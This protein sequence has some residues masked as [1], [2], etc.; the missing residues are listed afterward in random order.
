M[1]EIL[2]NNK[3]YLDIADTI[4]QMKDVNTTYKPRQMASALKDIYSNEVEGILPLSFE[5]NGNNLLDY[6]IDGASGGV[7]DRTD[8]LFDGILLDGY[9]TDNTLTTLTSSTG[10]YK[11]LKVNLPAGTYTVVYSEAVLIIRYIELNGDYMTNPAGKSTVESY[12]FT[13]NSNST[14]SLGFRN[15][16][17]TQWDDSIKIQVVT[18]SIVP[19]KY[20][21][22]G[23]K[24]PVVM[25]GKNLFDELQVVDT[26]VSTEMSNYQIFKNNGK[27]LINGLTTSSQSDVE[28]ANINSINN[29]ALQFINSNEAQYIFSAEVPGRIM[30]RYKLLGSDVVRYTFDE[31][32]SSNRVADRIVFRL[33]QNYQYNNE[34]MNIMFKLK[35]I[36]SDNYEA[37]H[38]QTITNI[39]LD[40]PIEAKA[41]IPSEYEEVEYIES[42]G[43][44]YI[45]TNYTPVQG[46]D[47]EF[48]NVTIN[49]FN[50]ALFSAGI[51]SYQ[52]ILL[53][54]GSVCYYKY[55]QTGNAVASSFSTITNG[56]IKVLN[57]NLYINNVLKAEADYG[58]AVDT[59]LNI[60]RRANNTSNLIG[61][62]GEIIISNNGII[63]R[64]FIPCYRKSDNVAG[65]YDLVNNTFYTN[66]GTGNFIVGPI[67][68]NESIS[69][70]DTNV[71]I[72]TIDGT[73]VITI[74]TTV[75]P[76]NVYI[77]APKD[78]PKMVEARERLEVI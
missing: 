18:G 77:Q 28:I 4:R 47:L 1:A 3:N 14:I 30:I 20:E 10:I 33:Q 73:N 60:F 52:L 8:N 71:N 66:Q 13:L 49:T 6:R 55:F 29:Q 63:K 58:G 61:K 57:G 68:E 64:D 32:N 39:Y 43:T 56:N 21:P 2:T 59:T 26:T 78:T 51:E 9:Y 54:L 24:V 50:G 40:E 75:Q 72:P 74:D 37:Y 62:I 16:T 44:Q 65:L 41:N 19:S 67:K 15:S 5:A 25:N 70:S 36:Q 31:Y 46:D 34:Q 76:S 11:S 27:L 38:E 7:G 42:T 35:Q 69:L 23:Y 22:Y 45:D 17:N 12:T 48:K 53:G